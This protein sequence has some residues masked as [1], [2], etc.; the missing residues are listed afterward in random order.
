MKRKGLK[1]FTLLELLIVL[2]ILSVALTLVLPALIKRNLNDMALFE[3]RVRSALDEVSLKKDICANFKDNYISIGGVNI[4]L[5]SP[6]RLTTFVKPFTL[7][8]GENRN[9]YCFTASQ[10]TVAGFVA[11]SKNNYLLIAVF[12]PTGEV[13][14]YK[15]DEAEAETF[16]DKVSKGRILEWF[17]SY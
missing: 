6:Y 16:K 8:S 3:N 17:N 2:V 1:G 12:L 7:V 4:L 10:P 9:S 15:T 11:K 13:E 14:F 5:P